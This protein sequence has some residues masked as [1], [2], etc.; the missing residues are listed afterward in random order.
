MAVKQSLGTLTLI[1]VAFFLSLALNSPV[2][3]LAKKLPAKKKN[4]GGFFATS[5]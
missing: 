2:Q 4:Q 3:W 1:G 5:N